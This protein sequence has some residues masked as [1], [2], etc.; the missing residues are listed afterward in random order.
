[1]PQTWNP[2]VE[3]TTAGTTPLKGLG[4]EPKRSWPDPDM[5]MC[6]TAEFEAVGQTKA[7]DYPRSLAHVNGP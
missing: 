3:M 6:G 5:K 2:P 1:M 4:H 7:N